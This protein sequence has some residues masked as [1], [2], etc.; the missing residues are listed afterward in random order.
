MKG[1]YDSSDVSRSYKSKKAKL[2]RPNVES[3]DVTAIL[4]ALDLLSAGNPTTETFQTISTRSQ[5]FL[6]GKQD[7]IKAVV[8]PLDMINVVHSLFV[9]SPDFQVNCTE[10]YVIDRLRSSF[11]V[12]MFCVISGQCCI[13][14]IPQRDIC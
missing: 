9:D 14:G 3:E 10:L 8:V 4:E 13:H 6:A 2:I 12:S 7:P 11:E 5:T 1:S